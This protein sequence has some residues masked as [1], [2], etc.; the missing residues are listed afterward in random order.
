MTARRKPVSAHK[1]IV[2][3]IGSA[4]LVDRDSGLKSA[5]LESLCSDIAALQARPRPGLRHPKP[6]CLDLGD[7]PRIPHPSPWHLVGSVL[8]FALSGPC[9]RSAWD[10]IHYRMESAKNRWKPGR[11]AD[12]CCDRTCLTP[13]AYCSFAYRLLNNYGFMISIA[14]LTYKYLHKLR[15]RNQGR[16]GGRY[17]YFPLQSPQ[18]MSLAC[19]LIYLKLSKHPRY[20]HWCL[21]NPEMPRA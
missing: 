3:K 7:Q 2:I 12:C 18:H 20:S 14:N 6:L 17:S 5:W 21:S 9:L 11:T 10:E 8:S 13:D 16:R 15:L 1:R 19:Y 4:L